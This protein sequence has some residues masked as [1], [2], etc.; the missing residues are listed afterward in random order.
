MINSKES[1]QSN[2][3]SVKEIKK[4]THTRFWAYTYKLIY[5]RIILSHNIFSD[6]FFHLQAFI[7]IFYLLVCIFFVAPLFLIFVV[8]P[9]R[10]EE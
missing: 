1:K 6:L 8:I 9:I 7:I 3:A 4:N 2:K 5:I 10:N